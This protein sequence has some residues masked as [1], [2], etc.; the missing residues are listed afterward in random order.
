MS[1]QVLIEQYNKIEAE[2][3]KLKQQWCTLNEIHGDED[4]I[5]YIGQKLAE[6]TLNQAHI[7]IDLER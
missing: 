7:L 5:K 1:N 6:L 2:R 3:I 4:K